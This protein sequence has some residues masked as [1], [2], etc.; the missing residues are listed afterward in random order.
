MTISEG[1][2]L[3]PGFGFSGGF[4][5]RSTLAWDTCLYALLQKTSSP[6]NPEGGPF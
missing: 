4:F 2:R 1:G 3:K 5:T 6:L